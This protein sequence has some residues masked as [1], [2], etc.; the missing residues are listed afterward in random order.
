MSNADARF[1]DPQWK[2]ERRLA[3]I[4]GERALLLDRIIHCNMHLKELE[5]EQTQ[6]RKELAKL[7]LLGEQ[8]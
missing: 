2:I 3:D 1:E 8:S 7:Q 4:Y 6:L 5:T